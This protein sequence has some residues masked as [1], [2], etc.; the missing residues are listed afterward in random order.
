VDKKL[1]YYYPE[2]LP[3]RRKEELNKS[4]LSSELTNVKKEYSYFKHI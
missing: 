1:L 3:E 2:N 4:Q